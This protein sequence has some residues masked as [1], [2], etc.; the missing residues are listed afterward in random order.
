MR[1]G[2]LL[3][4]FPARLPLVGAIAE[5]SWRAEIMADLEYG[6]RWLDACSSIAGALK[7]LERPERNG[8]AKHSEAYAYV[9]Q[10]VRE[11]RHALAAWC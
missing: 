10:Y 6:L 9:E 11:P 2:L 4:E 8:P 3:G 5:R 1:R 7:E